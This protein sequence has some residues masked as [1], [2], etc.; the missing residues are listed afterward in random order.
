MSKHRI[1]LGIADVENAGVLLL[2]AVDPDLGIRVLF[3]D[4]LP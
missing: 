1:E 2:C 4:G 3:V